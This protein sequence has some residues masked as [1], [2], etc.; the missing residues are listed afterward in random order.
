MFLLPR[1]PGY[2]AVPALHP[3]APNCLLYYTGAVLSLDH[4]GI[5]PAYETVWLYPDLSA[6]SSSNSL[7]KDA[8]ET[9]IHRLLG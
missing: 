8:Y 5:I 3:L 1:P 4:L 6:L 7:R 2:V 9:E